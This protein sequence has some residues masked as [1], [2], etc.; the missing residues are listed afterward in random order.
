M[1]RFGRDTLADEHL[2]AARRPV[3]RIPLRH[4]SNGSRTGHTNP[5]VCL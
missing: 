1:W 5:D 4:V 3:Q 2:Q